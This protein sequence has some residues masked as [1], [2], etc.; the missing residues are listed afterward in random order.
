[1]KSPDQIT[2][3]QEVELKLY[4][5][6]ADPAGLVVRLAQTALLARRKMSR[7]LLYNIYF[8]TPDQVLRQQRIAL[9]LRRIGDASKPQWLQ[10]LKTGG[11]DASALSRR[12]EWESAVAG[13]ALDLEAL[14]ATPWQ[15][16][17]PDGA[18]FATL[19]PC[20]V[21]VF[22]RCSWQVRK[23]DGSWV[24]V[25]LDIGHLEADGKQAPLCELELELKAG[26]PSELFG[27]A[28]ELAQAV[29]VLPAHL[30]KAQRGFLLAQ[31]GLGQPCR[32]QPPKLVLTLAQPDLAQ[33]VLRE[34][35]AQFT[36]NLDALRTSD[37][38]EVVHQARVGW[39]RFRSALRLFKK[40]AAIAEV[41]S[42]LALKPLLSCLGNLR[43]LDVAARTTLPSLES[44]YCIGSPQLLASWQA[45]TIALTQAGELERQA[46]RR[47][48]QSPG[49]GANLLAISEWLETL[50][51]SGY[52]PPAHK[53]ALRHWAKRRILRLQQRLVQA[54]Q[55]ATM[56]AQQ[57][58]VRILAKRLRYG[59]ETLRDL[60]PKALAAL[61]H[62]QATQLQASLGD[63]RDMAQASALVASLDDDPAIAAYLRGVLVG[64]SVIK[65]SLG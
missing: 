48:L 63:S 13:P 25:A 23:R 39:R 56:P 55:A 44:G 59:V 6:S 27:L 28:R 29:A 61:C 43:N 21:T 12:G 10:T 5:P 51:A 17:D 60:L 26:L 37:D 57:H 1:M 62:A 65:P 41:P 45:A 32:A 8:D 22:E 31:N 54:Q 52:A 18:L 3:P 16:I 15:D 47:E 46:A 14:Q 11:S 2:S 53:R 19:T 9:R 35:F 30:S 58:Q 36:R 38:P 34:M 64:L 33:L 20:F 24:E 40:T 4:L 7:Q 50:T 49:V 42:W